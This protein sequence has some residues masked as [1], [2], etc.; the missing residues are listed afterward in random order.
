MHHVPINH[1]R[2]HP[3]SDWTLRGQGRRW[4]CVS[5][6]TRNRTRSALVDGMSR[7]PRILIDAVHCRSENTL[8][9]RC[10]LSPEPQSIKATATSTRL[11]R[12]SFGVSARET[13]DC[14]V[15]CGTNVV[16][17]QASDLTSEYASRRRRLR[18][19]RPIPC[20][21]HTPWSA[22]SKDSGMDLC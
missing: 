12:S 19:Y 11:Q 16:R 22:V 10:G 18:D 13:R 21:M 3:P 6:R 8:G 14:G 4:R 15:R 5:I 2:T 17:Q 7:R 20:G 1:F 9:C